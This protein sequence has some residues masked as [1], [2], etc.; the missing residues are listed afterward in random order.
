MCMESVYLHEAVQIGQLETTSF[1]DVCWSYWRTI[2]STEKLMR[3]TTL[4]GRENTPVS[5]IAFDCTNSVKNPT[6]LF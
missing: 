3:F 4:L 5:V 2:A 1:T 6:R